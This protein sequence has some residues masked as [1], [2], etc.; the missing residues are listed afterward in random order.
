MDGG[1]GGPTGLSGVDTLSTHSP[2]SAALGRRASELVLR[3]YD[4]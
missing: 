1:P 4:D 3:F 2:V